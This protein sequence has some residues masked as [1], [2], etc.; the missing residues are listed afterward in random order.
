MMKPDHLREF[1]GNMMGF[2][3]P[4]YVGVEYICAIL[5]VIQIINHFY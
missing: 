1:S 4:G 2:Y 3:N 5:R